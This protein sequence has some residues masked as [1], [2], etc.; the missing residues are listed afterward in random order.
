MFIISFLGSNFAELTQSNEYTLLSR[1]N[2]FYR[3]ITLVCVT[4]DIGREPIWDYLGIEANETTAIEPTWNATNGISR[5]RIVTTQ[6]GYYTCTLTRGLADKYSVAV[7]KADVTTR[8]S[9]SFCV[10]Y[11]MNY[12]SIFYA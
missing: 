8:K 9:N 1:N 7:F 12:F 3:D 11:C 5:V 4:S 10:D 6:Q 2:T